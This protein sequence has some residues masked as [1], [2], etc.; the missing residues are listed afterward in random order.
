MKKFLTVLV[1]AVLSGVAVVGT[2]SSADARWGWGYGGWRGGWGYGGWGYPRCRMLRRLGL[3][4]LGL[5]TW[6]LCG[7]C[8]DRRNGGDAL[9]LLSGPGLSGLLLLFLSGAGLLLLWRGFWLLLLI[10]DRQP[11][12]SRV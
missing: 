9:L 1:A 6:R 11:L 12:G 2:S 3:S 4:R 7:W 5:G 10:P 8:R